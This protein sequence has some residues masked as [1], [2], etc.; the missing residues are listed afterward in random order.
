MREMVRVCKLTTDLATG[1]WE[2]QSGLLRPDRR[3]PYAPLALRHTPARAHT[4]GPAEE[5]EASR[6]EPSAR[7]A[8]GLRIIVYHPRMDSLLHY[9]PE[10]HSSFEIIIP[11]LRACPWLL[12]AQ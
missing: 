6:L 10:Y 2:A 5:Q 4:A 3:A 12:L 8:S 9:A 7:S 11:S 1:M